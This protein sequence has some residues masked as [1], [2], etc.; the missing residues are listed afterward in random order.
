MFFTGT[1]SSREAKEKQMTL[2]LRDN[3]NRDV[4]EV[5]IY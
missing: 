4:A 1:G 5:E 2:F 3:G